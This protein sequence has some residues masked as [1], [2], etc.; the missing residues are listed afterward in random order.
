MMMVTSRN[1]I[2]RP[3]TISGRSGRIILTTSA[4]SGG[5]TNAQATH[6]AASRATPA[7]S[8][9]LSG[10]VFV[11]GSKNSAASLRSSSG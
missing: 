5:S 2:A 10:N 6:M 3:D 4:T 1:T 11:S 9:S 7:H 8:F